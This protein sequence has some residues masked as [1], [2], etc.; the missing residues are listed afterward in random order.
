MFHSRLIFLG[1][2][3]FYAGKWRKSGSEGMSGVLG[4][5]DGEKAAVGT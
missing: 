4:G 3:F 2:L 5:V 1:G